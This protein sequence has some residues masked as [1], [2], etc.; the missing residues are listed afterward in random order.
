MGK[1]CDLVLEEML[2]RSGLCP[3]MVPG[4]GVGGCR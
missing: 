1:E 3:C 2:K 4:E